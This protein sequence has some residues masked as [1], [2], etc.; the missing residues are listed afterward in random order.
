MA[1]WTLGRL[2]LA[3]L[4]EVKVATRPTITQPCTSE[5]N[6]SPPRPF[7]LP[8]VAAL[9]RREPPTP[10][11]GGVSGSFIQSETTRAAWAS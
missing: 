11:I 3:N 2:G 1:D 10:W 5:A 9:P 7:H 8:R 4:P 6:I